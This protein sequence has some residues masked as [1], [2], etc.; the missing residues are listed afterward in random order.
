MM[1]TFEVQ[2]ESDRSMHV[3]EFL[4]GLTAFTMG[5][6]VFL[7]GR[8]DSEIALG[9]HSYWLGA[10]GLLTSGYSWVYMLY[11]ATLNS[12]SLDM[13][14]VICLAL[15]VASGV[16]LVR[17]GAGLI[18]EAGPLPLW[19]SLLPL[20]LIVPATLLIAYGIVVMMTAGD[21]KTSIIEWSRYL[22][23]LPGNILTALGFFRQWRKLR[24]VG[25]VSASGILL[26]TGGVFLVNG[27]FSGAVTE[28]MGLT[29]NRITELTGISIDT[30]RV[31]VMALLA[32]LV[33]R[34]MNVFEI[35]RQQ[36]LRRLEDARREAQKIALTIHTKTHQ[37]VEVWLDA[38]VKIGHRIAGMDETDEVLKDV[39]TEACEILAADSAVIVLYESSG[40]LSYRV[41]F[42]RGEA[43]IVAPEPV[44]NDLIRRAVSMNAPLR[45]PED[46]GGE[47][48][49]WQYKGQAIYAET[50]ALVPLKMKQTLIGALW[51]GR[52]NGKPF[53]CTDLIG[54]GHIANQVV[55]ALEHASMAARLQSFAVV[56]ERSRIAREMHDSLAQILGYLGLETQ[57]LEALVRQGDQDAVLAELREARESIKSAQ[58]DVR[59]NILSLRTALAGNAGLISALKEYVEEFGIQ[60]GIATEIAGHA[61]D[62]LELSPL[63]EAQCVRIVQEALTNVR[64]HAQAKHVFVAMTSLNDQLEIDITDDGIGFTAGTV[65]HGHFGLQTI[66]ERADSV[67]GRVAISS[68]P[69]Q[70]TSIT[71]NL[72]LEYQEVR[73]KPYAA[74]A[75]ACS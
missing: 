41:Q 70:G 10:Y 19:L 62:D 72:P 52:T 5:L 31:L 27:F 75:S 50:A 18:A 20:A 9:H 53:T 28:G 59:E 21:V 45:Y 73:A 33:T 16:A 22:L 36:E 74:A 8:G 68:Q 2:G 48:F 64:K 12:Q 55:I 7:R 3:H 49:A 47:A 57:T 15:L 54:L 61:P 30:W 11:G 23:I 13:T 56:E 46:I 60:T 39:I 4:Y 43:S 14:S 38:L 67:G 24:Q 44:R 32:V 71:L 17:F 6:V 58:A 35:E 42:A 37:Q 40:Q 65:P 29:G 34:S 69:G 51:L 63:V 26:A 25:N 1:K 66:R